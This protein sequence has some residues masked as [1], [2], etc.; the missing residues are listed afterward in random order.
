[1]LIADPHVKGKKG[2]YPNLAESRAIS[3]KDN[4]ITKYVGFSSILI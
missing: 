2:S 1:M 3:M 4:T